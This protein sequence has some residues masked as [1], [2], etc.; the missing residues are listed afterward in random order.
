MRA[1]YHRSRLCGLA[2]S[3]DY[4]NKPRKRDDSIHVHVFV[5]FLYSVRVNVVRRF[6]VSPLLTRSRLLQPILAVLKREAPRHVNRKLVFF[7]ATAWEGGG[8]VVGLFLT[9]SHSV[10]EWNGRDCV[11]GRLTNFVNKA[12]IC[13]VYGRGSRSREFSDQLDTR[14]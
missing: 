6:C 2:S 12:A 8:G 3:C 9:L 7:V 11:T 4:A 1:R 10:S 13:D 14:I 5:A